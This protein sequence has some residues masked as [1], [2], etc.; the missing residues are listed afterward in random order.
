MSTPLPAPKPRQPQ[1]PRFHVP[2]WVRIKRRIE[3]IS[4]PLAGREGAIVK[5]INKTTLRVMVRGQPYDMLM[6]ELRA[7]SSR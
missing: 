4:G 1:Q 6:S 7:L 5:V 2:R 3:V